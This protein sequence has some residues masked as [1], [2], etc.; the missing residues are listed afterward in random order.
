MTVSH[1]L[2]L[3]GA[4]TGPSVKIR[5]MYCTVVIGSGEEE[6]TLPKNRRG[7]VRHLV[8]HMSGEKLVFPVPCSISVADL[9][10]WP[11]PCSLSLVLRGK[12]R[13]KVIASDIF[14]KDIEGPPGPCLFT[15]IKSQQPVYIPFPEVPLELWKAMKK[16]RAVHFISSFP[17]CSL[18]VPWCKICHLHIGN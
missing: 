2:F 3:L 9:K 12:I 7:T 11:Q 14:G 6:V 18:F 5:F 10:D 4:L 8:V 16:P 15:S 1:L 13:I 17:Q